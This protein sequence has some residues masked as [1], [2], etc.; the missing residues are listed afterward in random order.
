[1][2]AIVNPKVIVLICF[3]DGLGWQNNCWVYEKSLITLSD[4]VSEKVVLPFSYTRLSE[5]ESK[6]DCD[7]FPYFVFRSVILD[8][9]K[10]YLLR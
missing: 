2:A 1:M 10:K 8:E 3:Y 4:T 5:L 7:V 9:D 6:K